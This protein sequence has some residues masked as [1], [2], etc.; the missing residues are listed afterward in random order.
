LGYAVPPENDGSEASRNDGQKKRG[1]YGV[2]HGGALSKRCPHRPQPT[3]PLIVTRFTRLSRTRRQR[4]C[5]ARHF[6]L[7]SED[8]QRLCADSQKLVHPGHGASTRRLRVGMPPESWYRAAQADGQ[9][10]PKRS[11]HAP[12][13][14]ETSQARVPSL[15]YKP[16]LQPATTLSTAVRSK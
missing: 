2:F 9:S 6:E 11:E 8:G 15:A 10:S 13:H 7:P 3:C 5:A 4:L 16:R 14:A 12:E 1:G